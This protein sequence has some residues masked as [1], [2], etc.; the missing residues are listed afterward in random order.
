MPSLDPPSADH[1]STA[2]ALRER[3]TMKEAAVLTISVKT[4]RE[5]PAASKAGNPNVP[6]EPN[7]IAISEAIVVPPT[8]KMWYGLVKLRSG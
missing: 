1:S 7:L 5:K 3:L 2:A 8:C 4:N 6:P